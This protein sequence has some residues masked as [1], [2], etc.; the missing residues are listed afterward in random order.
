MHYFEESASLLAKVAKHRQDQS[1]P[2]VH[3]KNHREVA[4]GSG[5]GTAARSRSSEWGIRAFTSSKK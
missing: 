2:R 1:R 4:R 3:A 5:D